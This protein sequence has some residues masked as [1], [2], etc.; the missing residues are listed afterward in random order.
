M[1]VGIHADV[2]DAD[3]R[4]FAAQEV[5]EV[6]ARLME[7][8]GPAMTMQYQILVRGEA[9]QRPHRCRA[10]RPMARPW[11]RRS[12]DHG[13]SVSAMWRV[14]TRCLN[15]QGHYQNGV[16]ATRKAPILLGPP[17]PRF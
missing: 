2:E 9:L 16:L 17:E 14:V 13:G 4:D 7:V 15:Y 12:V 10:V 11:C 3:G 6:R 5:G 8:L 1:P